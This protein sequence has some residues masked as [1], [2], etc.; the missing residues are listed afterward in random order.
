[1]P[2]K[3][4]ILQPTLYIIPQRV[5]DT[6]AHQSA[7]YPFNY[8]PTHP[9]IHPS[10]CPS[11]CPLSEG[12]LPLLP[13]EVVPASKHDK[14]AKDGEEDDSISCHHQTAGT[15]LDCAFAG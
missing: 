8:P 7:V 1:M 14:E 12:A 3:F 9:S 10:I 2:G 5:Q 13:A 6:C 11:V 15:P 4:D